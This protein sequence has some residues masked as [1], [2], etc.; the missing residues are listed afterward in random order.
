MRIRPPAR[1]LLVAAVCTFLLPAAII[2]PSSLPIVAS[3]AQAAASGQ[4][5]PNASWALG[6]VVPEGASLHGGDKLLWEEVSNLTVVFTLPNI[7][8]PDR[9]VYAVL[10]V[11]TSDGG[12]L[13][14][15]AGIGPNASVWSA[16]SWSIPDVKSIPLTYNWILNATGPRMSPGAN[17]TISIFY[18]SGSWNLR[19]TDQKTG[20]STER[21]FPQGQGTA[22][23]VG[24]QEV[25][26]FESYSR[27][28]ATFRNMGNLTLDSILV[29]GARV[30]SGVYAYGQWDPHKNP[31]FVVGSSGTSPPTW[32]S[33][34]QTADGSFVWGYGTVWRNVGDSMLTVLEWSILFLLVSSSVI[35]AVLWKTRKPRRTLIRDLH[36]AAVRYH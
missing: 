31:L 1:R 21:E 15:A 12:V 19:T 35:L 14:A 20:I 5:Y 16:Y 4:T 9:M 23:K 11:M 2:A 22:L 3:T 36:R 10:S 32:I 6:L 17:V 30:V 28:G 18:S 26:S 34:G 8:M 24:D 27:L 29:N 25:F 33:L 13:Q 7:S